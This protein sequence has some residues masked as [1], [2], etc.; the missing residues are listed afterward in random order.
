MQ[1]RRQQRRKIAR[2]ETDQG[3]FGRDQ[4]GHHH[5]AD[6]A[7]GNRVARPRSFMG[8][9]SDEPV[10]PDQ[11]RLLGY[12]IGDGYVGGKT[13]IHFIN[14]QES[15]LQDVARIA[16]TLGCETK[17]AGIDAVALSHRPGEKNGALDL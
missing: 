2:S 13:P 3:I 5:F 7:R 16:A 14:V 6:L 4:R 10:P 17:S 1:R 8:F 15:L 11:A 12:L 9:G